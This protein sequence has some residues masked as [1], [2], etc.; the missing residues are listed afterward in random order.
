MTFDAGSTIYELTAADGTTFVMQSW[1]QE[2][3]PEMDEAALADLGA[4]LEL[5]EAWTYEVRTLDEPLRVVTTTTTAKVIQDEFR[6]SY[7]MLTG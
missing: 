2:I 1:S 4:R 5:P 3:D 7:S 6:N